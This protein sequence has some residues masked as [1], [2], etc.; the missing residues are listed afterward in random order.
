MTGAYIAGF[1][2]TAMAL[3]VRN[4]IGMLMRA[5]GLFQRGMGAARARFGDKAVDTAVGAGKGFLRDRAVMLPFAAVPLV[6]AG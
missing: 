1:V 4:P 2:K 5:R 3:N 6:A